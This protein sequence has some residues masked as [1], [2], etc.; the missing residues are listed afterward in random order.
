MV[1]FLHP[2]CPCSRASLEE[3]NRLLV[4]CRGTLSA[5]VL[6]VRP[7]G[8]SDDWAKTGLCKV[9]ASIPG[10]QVGFDPNG[11]EANRFGAE[12]SGCVVLYSPKGELLF[13]GGITGSRS[14]VGENPG[15]DAV[16]ALANGEPAALNHTHVY[17]CTLLDNS[18][19]GTNENS[20]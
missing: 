14:H 15:E 20:L 10:V 16:I 1:M 9:A 5:H 8:V 4:Q 17:G 18:E 13:S 7:K 19:N 6:F 2:Y 12:S 11:D 3:L